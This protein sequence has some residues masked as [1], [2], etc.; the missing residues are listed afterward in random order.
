MFTQLRAD[1]SRPTIQL[2]R[3]VPETGAVDGSPGRPDARRSRECSGCVAV[4][5]GEKVR[6]NVHVRQ[7]SGFGLSSSAGVVL[8]VRSRV[9]RRSARAT[10][11]HRLA[12]RAE[13]PRAA[14]GRSRRTARARRTDPRCTQEHGG[15]LEVALRVARVGLERR[16]LEDERTERA[17][18]AQRCRRTV[19][20]LS[21]ALIVRRSA[22]VAVDGD[23]LAAAE[24]L[25][26]P[27]SRM[28]RDEHVDDIADAG[29]EVDH[30]RAPTESMGGADPWVDRRSEFI[31]ERLERR[32]GV[33]PQLLGW[34]RCAARCRHRWSA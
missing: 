13:E 2:W 8:L 29:H 11:A 17:R 10:H 19:L 22:W 30:R 32:R 14:G 7:S 21:L 16:S 23:H 33:L 18:H 15:V 34:S 25:A 28:V 6:R 24:P 4:Q 1:A 20:I 31:P 12:T 27:G 9:A 26:G 5:F 3:I